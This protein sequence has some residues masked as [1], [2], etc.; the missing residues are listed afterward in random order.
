M[1]TPKKSLFNIGY[2]IRAFRE[3]NNLTQEQLAA[4]MNCNFKTVGNLEN[5][6]TVPDLKQIINLCDVLKI[7]MD[8]LFADVLHKAEH[9]AEAADDENTAPFAGRKIAGISPEQLQKIETLSLKLRN[10]S[11]KELSITDSLIDSLLQNR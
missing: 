7:S 2:K 9:S 8:E 1:A 10:L 3:A 6:R 4:F 11:E 5:D